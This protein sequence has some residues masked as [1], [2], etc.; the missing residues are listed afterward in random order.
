MQYCNALLLKVTFPDTG[1]HYIVICRTE[2]L[3][4]TVKHSESRMNTACWEAEVLFCV[5]EQHAV[6]FYSG[7]NRAQAGDVRIFLRTR[8]LGWVHPERYVRTGL[9]RLGVETNLSSG[10]RKRSGRYEPWM[11]CFTRTPG[12][13]CESCRGGVPPS[14]CRRSPETSGT[15]SLTKNKP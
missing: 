14:V 2:Q 5:W 7:L 9:R 4:N 6:V 3:Y 13:F 1:C 10:G 15:I 12:L 11:C 8:W